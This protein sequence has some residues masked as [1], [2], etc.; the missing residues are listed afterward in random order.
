MGSPGDR[1]GTSAG[2]A[3]IIRRAS[4][5]VKCASCYTEGR[6]AVERPGAT[7][8]AAR[9]AILDGEI[10]A[11]DPAIALEALAES[12]DHGCHLGGTCPDEKADSAHLGWLLRGGEREA[13]PRHEPEAGYPRALRELAAADVWPAVR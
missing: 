4:L 11:L 6:A 7:K 9:V 8:A 1:L 3:P 2:G 12:L 5:S 13:T 10:L